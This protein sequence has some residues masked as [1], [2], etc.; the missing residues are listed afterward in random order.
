MAKKNDDNIDFSALFKDA[1]PVK[2]DTYVTSAT[3]DSGKRGL[4][5]KLAKLEK[6]KKR[7]NKEARERHQQSASVELSDDYEAHWPDNKAVKY[8]SKDIIDKASTEQS[9][10]YKDL[11]KK[12][13]MARIPP[14]I[15][16]DLH[17]LTAQQAKAEI[18]SVIFEA[19]KR[20]YPCINIIHGH[21]GGILK[22][23][24]PNWLIQ[25]PDIAGFV[26]APRAYG[27]K[28]GLLVLIATD[29]AN[30]KDI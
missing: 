20:H 2:H 10:I 8:L 7:I 28:A 14:D 29:F 4:D 19:K 3:T 26:Q 9:L 5:A 30:L 21:G 13:S 22:Q 24:V 18:I 27:G 1:K 23:K 6:E 15:E 25:H 11:L 16:L 17:G 12:L